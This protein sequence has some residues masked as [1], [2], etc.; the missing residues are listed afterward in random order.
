[1][2]PREFLRENAE[3]LLSEM[4]ERYAASGIEGF[5]ALDRRRREA[6]TRLEQVR[7]RRNELIAP[8]GKPSP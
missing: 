2:L 5:A 8:R 1:M 7:R 6:V 4:P 3:R